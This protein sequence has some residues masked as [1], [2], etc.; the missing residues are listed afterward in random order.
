VQER[1]LSRK[2]GCPT[3]HALAHDSSF[4]GTRSLQSPYREAHDHIRHGVFVSIR[5]EGRF[6]WNLCVACTLFASKTRMNWLRKL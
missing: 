3:V 2:D 5:N 4:R 6:E 1:P